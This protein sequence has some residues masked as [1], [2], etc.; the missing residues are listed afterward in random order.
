MLDTYNKD[1]TSNIIFIKSFLTSISS[2]PYNSIIIK[3]RIK[4][5]LFGLKLLKFVVIWFINNIMLIIFINKAQN[6]L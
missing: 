4:N 3:Q 5:P 6:N 1:N 2:S